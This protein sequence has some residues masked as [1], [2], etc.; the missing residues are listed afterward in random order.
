MDKMTLFALSVA[1]IVTGGYVLSGRLKFQINTDSVVNRDSTTARGSVVV[2]GKT[3]SVEYARTMREQ[4]IGLMN[5]KHL[6]EDS[7][8]LFVFSMALPRSFWNHNTQI[9]LDVIWIR[10]GVVIGVSNLPS[11]Q[12]KSKTII[13]PGIADQVLEVNAGFAERYNIKKGSIIK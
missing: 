1:L 9:P 12:E 3:I 6:D 10:G 7:G 13:S 8:M 4:Q 11:I 5:R 2:E